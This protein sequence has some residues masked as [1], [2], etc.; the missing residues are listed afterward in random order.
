M[1]SR[2]EKALLD[3]VRLPGAFRK[4]MPNVPT[5][6]LEL[7]A[8]ERSEV[9]PFT[10]DK[11]PIEVYERNQDILNFENMLKTEMPQRDWDLADRNLE[12]RMTM[13]AF[14]QLMGDQVCADARTVTR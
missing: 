1:A 5:K 10:H 2:E 4:E 12:E 6:S 8:M 9:C 13:A 3:Q 7:R 14:K 11:M